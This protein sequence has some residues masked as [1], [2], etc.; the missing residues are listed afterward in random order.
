MLDV[1]RPIDDVISQARNASQ[2]GLA[3]VWALQIF[4][5]DALS[6]LAMVGREVPGIALGTAVVPIQPR[7]PIVMATQALTVQAAAGDRLTLGVGL[8][9]Q[10]V[11]E[12][13]FGYPFEKNALRMREY[14]SVLVPL[15]HGEQVSFQG[16]TVRANTLGALDVKGVS[17]PGVLVGALAPMMLQVAGELADGTVTWMTGPTT[18]REHVVP[19]ILKAASEVG[20]PAPRVVVGLPICVTGDEAAARDRVAKAFVIYGHLPSYRAML[21]REGAAGPAEVAIVGTAVQVR[22]TLSSLAE[23]GATEVVAVLTGNS[24]EREATMEVLAEASSSMA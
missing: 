21:D 13:V 8:S 7:H 23:G 18:I 14:L 17:A 16:E 3:S 5:Y 22:S 15:L 1:D 11:I 19:R 4:G 6:L 10:V 9:H 12:G 24:A 20:R 2:A